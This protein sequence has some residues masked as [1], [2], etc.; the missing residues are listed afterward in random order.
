MS[1]SKYPEHVQRE[2]RAVFDNEEAWT[3][4]PLLPL[5]RYVSDGSM[6]ELA[7]VT[8]KKSDGTYVVQHRMIFVAGD[9]N[10]KTTTYKDGDSLFADGWVVD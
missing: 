8:P 7:L 9:E 3:H 5:K 1:I 4:W 10:T 6:P 2:M